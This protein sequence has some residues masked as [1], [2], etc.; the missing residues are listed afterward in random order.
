[1]VSVGN[2]P[3]GV[4]IFF[5]AGSTLY[6]R[7]QGGAADAAY[8]WSPAASTCYHIAAVR[9]GSTMYL[10]VNGAQQATNTN[11]TDIQTTVGLT[12]GSDAGAGRNFNGWIEELRVEKGVAKWTAGFTSPTSEYSGPTSSGTGTVISNAYAEPVAPTE[13]IVIADEVL[14][15]GTITYY[16]SRDNG[17]TW[18]SC[19]KETLCSISGQPSGTQLKWKA[20][21]T[22]AAE[23]N[24]ISV[25][26]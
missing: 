3:N 20:V 23:L 19:A 18:T 11:S 2:D 17:T 4:E 24:A 22:D 9:A 15:G 5:Y 8:A 26:V 1:M 25:A 12:V 21:L 13:A 7:I 14:N 16:V 6:F 10:F